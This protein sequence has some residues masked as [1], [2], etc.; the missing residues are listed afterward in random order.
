MSALSILPRPNTVTDPGLIYFSNRAA[1]IAVIVLGTVYYTWIKSQTGAPPKAPTSS[2]SPPSSKEVD[3]EAGN[4]ETEK[5]RD[6]DQLE[7]EGRA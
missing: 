3:L 7:K 4:G 2:V 6:D 5:L 1:S